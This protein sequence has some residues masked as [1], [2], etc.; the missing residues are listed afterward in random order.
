MKSLIMI[1][2]K[3]LSLSLLFLVLTVS[4]TSAALVDN[5]DGTV[6]DTE[7]GL[8]WQQGEGGLMNWQSALAYC[9]NLPL[10]G[11]DDWRLPDRNELESLIDYDYYN[12]AIYNHNINGSGKYFPGGLS[13]CWSSTTNASYPG[14]AWRVSFRSGVV[15][16]S[17]QS[18]SY[19][20]RAVRSGQ[21]GP[22]DDSAILT[23]SPTS[24]TVAAG[25]GSTTFAVS[26]SGGGTMNWTAA[27][28][29]DWLTISS[30]SSGTNSGTVTVAYADNTEESSRLGAVTVDAPG[31]ENSHQVL[32]IE[33]SKEA[34][35]EGVLDHFEF[36]PISSPQQLKV[37]FTILV[38]ALDA[39]NNIVDDYS[40]S[41]TLFSCQGPIKP[42]VLTFDSG[43]ATCDVTI[44]EFGP[45]CLNCSYGD[46]KGQSNGFEVEGCSGFSDV[47]GR[48]V[49]NRGDPIVGADVIAE[50]E[51][52]GR[53]FR[54][55]TQADGEYFFYD[56]PCG[57]YLIFGSAK[58]DDDLYDSKRLAHIKCD[59][60]TV[61]IPQK[62][63]QI[64]Q[65]NFGTPVIFVPGMLASSA[66]FTNY[67]GL[68]KVGPDRYLHIHLKDLN[69]KLAGL[70][71]TY[72]PFG[73]GSLENSLK[74]DLM[75]FD[76]PWDW[77]LGA[78]EAAILYLIPKI[79]EALQHS[80]TGKV[81]IVAHS[82]GGLLAR[83][84]I[85][86]DICY[87]P[88]VK[89]FEKID[90]LVMIAT[91][92]LGSCNPYFLWEGGDPL[93]L[94]NTV[95][96]GVGPGNAYS[97]TIGQLWKT[98]Y[99]HKPWWSDKHCE[100][101]NFLVN[102]VCGGYNKP[103]SLRQLMSTSDFL[104]SKVSTSPIKWES[105]GIESLGNE[106]IWL[107]QLNESENKD[108]M[109]SWDNSKIRTISFAG[110]GVDTI[111]Q[112]HVAR[113]MVGNECHCMFGEQSPALQRY[114]YLDGLPNY[115]LGSYEVTWGPGDGTVPFSSAIWLYGQGC[116]EFGGS[117]FGKSHTELPG[118]FNDQVYKFLTGIPR[119]R[120]SSR[121]VERLNSML[122]FTIDNGQRLM[123]RDPLGN[124]VGIDHNSGSVVDEIDGAY[125]LF[126]G[127][128][129]VVRLP[130]PVAGKYLLTY[131]GG[132]EREFDLT[133]D[134]VNGDDYKL[135][136]VSSF[137]PD[138][139]VTV[140]VFFD[141]LAASPILLDPPIDNCTKLTCQ[142]YEKDNQL[143]TRL[144][145]SD[146]AD[147]VEYRIYA[148]AAETE[149]YFHEMIEIT[150]IANPA[151]DT[152]EL[153]RDVEENQLMVYVVT[154][155]DAAGNES[156]FSNK[157]SNDDRDNDNLTDL[158]E[159][160][161]GTEVDNPDTDGDGLLDG[162]E[163]HSGISPKDPDSDDDGYGDYDEVQGHSDP[164]FAD[165]IP[166]IHV[167]DKGICNGE[168]FCY[169]TIAAACQ[170]AA[171]AGNIKVEQGSYSETLV[172]NQGKLLS[173]TGG[174]NSDYTTP[175]S[176]SVV[177]GSL[178][179]SS[180][181]L[182]VEKIVI[183]GQ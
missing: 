48:L 78:D 94:D 170:A 165:S 117:C 11:Y 35:L 96:W 72:D 87:S 175:E 2:G 39:N 4:F 100:I 44:Y 155:L 129:G 76:C 128:Q 174:W 29:D 3:G 54:T 93:G 74:D 120:Y 85:Q 161:F 160:I 110:L 180:G 181:C 65:A 176:D 89:Y 20:V 47:Q 84:L 90:K 177:V 183:G 125:I 1:I 159:V 46:C 71:V 162:D 109:S 147:A 151:Y 156:F 119:S 26:N 28:G 122:S 69:F 59:G 124:Q 138:K 108:R 166:D 75:T 27:T 157:V 150:K 163:V 73:W 51:F 68:S 16:Y 107:K 146:K 145:W 167:N 154:Y 114:R 112:V 61:K 133:I 79:D 82:M 60:Q 137:S 152:G 130:E 111:E 40:G 81:H 62:R 55:T 103:S 115:V 135:S 10:A 143:Y 6:S 22:L 172:L 127:C 178:T 45:N 116:S 70:P 99:A 86:S 123:V 34:S 12:P 64:N 139:P 37:P 97:N 38:R 101:M 49:D 121:S 66:T 8:M 98:Y 57:S 88:G 63:L 169:P 92:H 24:R 149:P 105:R 13:S 104:T 142:P 43:L 91:P 153:W 56:L 36:F 132:P 30:G 25:A 52:D 33:Q 15:D 134:F 164:R 171:G 77:R 31:A 182:T 106:N 58:G 21:S 23:I 141:P 173:L 179:I 17:G 131:F 148:V 50:L 41:S 113:T 136:S 158:N 14:G 168:Y 19:Y 80:T 32:Q 102:D 95:S 126:D 5:G 18:G 9:E 7:T 118:Q 144:Q 42:I 53:T 140:E 67:P 83:S